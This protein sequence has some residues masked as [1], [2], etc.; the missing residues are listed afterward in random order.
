MKLKFLLLILFKFFFI[1]AQ[2]EKINF[3][4]F[5]IINIYSETYLDQS[6]WELIINN[7]DTIFNFYNKTTNNEENIFF[8]VNKKIFEKKILKS[9]LLYTIKK[10]GK[11]IFNENKI[12]NFTPKSKHI[13]SRYQ[14]KE[15]KEIKGKIIDSYSIDS[16][17]QHFYVVRSCW[18]ELYDFWYLFNDKGLINIHSEKKEKQPFH[19]RKI[20]LTDLDNNNEPEVSFFYKKKEILKIIHFNNEE[21]LIATKTNN[22]IKQPT[23]TKENNKLIYR[24]FFNYNLNDNSE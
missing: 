16:E 23:E 2:E 3:I 19:T 18:K 11:I 5:G 7:N 13:L 8:N 14:F 20:I 4:D 12:L 22:K 15:S 9:S 1:I 10:D 6:N 17:K 24:G 21:K